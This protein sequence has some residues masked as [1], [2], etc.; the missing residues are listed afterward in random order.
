VQYTLTNTGS[1]PGYVTTL[2]A[3][4]TAIVRQAITVEM[5]VADPTGDQVLELK[6]PYQSSVALV[7]VLVTQLATLL[8]TPVARV[9]TIT[10]CAHVSDALMVAALGL[11]IGDRVAITEPVSGLSD[12]L[13]TI[14]GVQLEM[15]MIA[16]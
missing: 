7:D 9:Q 3:M 4:G 8:S 1:D 15:H 13:F 14:H 12:A 6:L 16:Q 10:F 2:V 5:T 11:E